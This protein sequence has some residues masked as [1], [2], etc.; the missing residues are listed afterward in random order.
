MEANPR[1]PMCFHGGS[2]E[3]TKAQRYLFLPLG[4]QRNFGLIVCS[5]CLCSFVVKIVTAQ[6]SISAFTRAPP[7][8]H[9]VTMMS[10]RIAD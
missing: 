1:S 9:K 3:D 8:I 5:S 7:Q 4:M 10:L 2:H 6:F